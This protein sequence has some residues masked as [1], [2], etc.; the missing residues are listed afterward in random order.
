M[1]VLVI[2]AGIAGLSAARRLVELGVDHSDLRVVDKGRGI[3]GRMASRRIE[4]PA[5][6]ARFDHGAQFFTTRSSIFADTVDAAVS[7]GAVV[8]WTRGFEPEADG[9]PRWR[10]REGMTGLCKWM[11]AD[12]GL[13]VEHGRR[14]LDLGDELAREPADAVIHT[15][16]VPQALATMAFCGMLPEP[17]LAD[18]LAAL[19]YKPTI[20]V[21]LVPAT[22]PTGLATHGGAQHNDDPDN[23]DLAFVTDNQAKGISE[24]PAVTIHLS[25]RT[26]AD[27][28]GASDDEVIDRALAAAADHLGPAADRSAALAVH[29]Q[30]WR[31]AGPVACWPD[32]T[33]VWG[34]APTIA[35]AGEAFAGPK[36]E[37]AFLSG[38]AAADTIAASL[39]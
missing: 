18:A 33:V 16:P 11:A 32:P 25:N 7:A 5:G 2:G 35:L 17:E 30:R 12:T 19:R 31:Y 38:R 27:L 4:T 28:W 37:G 6:T 20:A 9:F 10:G 39:S 26:S 23:P 21:L 3:G 29:V 22:S 8:E 1:R 34:H 14:V 15:A 24:I 36:V 13:T